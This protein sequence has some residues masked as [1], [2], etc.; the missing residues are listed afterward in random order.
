MKNFTTE[1]QTKIVEFYFQN[2]RSIILTQRAYCRYF[3]VRNSPSESMIR[4]LNGRFQKQ[5]SVS[6]LPRSRRLRTIHTEENIERVQV[7][8]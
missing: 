5:G 3:N 4:R 2:Q 1:Q 6:D 8:I 7:E